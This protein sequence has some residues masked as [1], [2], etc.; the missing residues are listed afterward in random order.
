MN[1]HDAR[2]T[3]HAAED[4]RYRIDTNDLLVSFNAGWESFAEVNDSPHLHGERITHRSLWD[5]ISGAETEQ[6][7]RA[8]LRKVRA[9]K[10]PLHLPFRCDSPALRRYMEIGITQLDNGEIEYCCR[11]LKVERRAPVPR[12]PVDFKPPSAPCTRMC[13][14]CNRIDIEGAWLEIEEA[15][16]HVGLLQDD[17]QQPF[18][19]TM[20]DD[21]LKTTLGDE[22][23]SE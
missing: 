2:T 8:L 4:V 15:V 14:W 22:I 12:V 23:D 13:S 11:L 10:G 9:G 18:T 5:F 21:C 3:N 1:D 17:L 6:V 20:C 19:H 7:H 16:A